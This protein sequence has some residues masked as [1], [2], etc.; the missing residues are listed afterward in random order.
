METRN[1]ILVDYIQDRRERNFAGY[2][3][4]D[5]D[6]LVRQTPNEGKGGAWVYF[7][8]IPEEDLDRII[9][10][11][12]SFFETKGIPFEWKLY[13]FDKPENLSDRLRAHDFVSDEEE[14]LMVLDLSSYSMH[15]PA[16]DDQVVIEQ[17]RD[18]STREAIQR[19]QEGIWNIDLSDNFNYL[20]DNEAIFS[21][22]VAKVHGEIIGSGW[23]EYLEGSKFP[24]LHGGAIAPQWRGKGIYSALLAIRLLEISQRGYQYITVD[25]APMSY[26]ILQKRGFDSLATSRPFKMNNASDLK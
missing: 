11:Q 23:T 10:D 2:H 12:I 8:N 21:H 5:L 15:E 26:P 19:F 6:Y 14:H 4:E 20:S 25:A 16:L 1:Q 7:S 3:R 13:N 24:E 22:Y 17:V 9:Q 18:S